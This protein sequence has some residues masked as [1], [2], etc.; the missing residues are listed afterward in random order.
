[1]HQTPG[2]CWMRPEIPLHPLALL[3]DPLLSIA[4]PSKTAAPKAAA[5]NAMLD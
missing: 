2:T 4:G 1:M 3:C 5:S